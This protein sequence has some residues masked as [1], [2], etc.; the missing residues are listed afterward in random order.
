MT[1]RG[2]RRVGLCLALAAL[3]ACGLKGDPLPPDDPR[4]QTEG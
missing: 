4:A 3:A 2:L 1:G